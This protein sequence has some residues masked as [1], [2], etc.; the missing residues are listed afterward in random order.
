MFGGENRVLDG[1][2]GSHDFMDNC[3]AYWAGTDAACIQGTDCVT[4]QSVC[5]YTTDDKKG[6][7]SWNRPG[8]CGGYFDME[9]WE[10]SINKGG[11]DTGRKTSCWSQ[12]SEIPE[13]WLDE[14]NHATQANWTAGQEVTLGWVTTANHGGMYEWSL[15]CDGDETY[16]NF[17]NNRLEV[18]PGKGGIYESFTM[19]SSPDLA[20]EEG[21]KFGPKIRDPIVSNGKHEAG[22]VPHW[23]YIPQAIP[24][25][26]LQNV[27]KIPKD[28][29]EGKF[30]TEHFRK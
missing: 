2:K 19:A 10:L 1:G 16:S 13:S 15:I 5:P 17:R 24:N 23:A 28:K 27:Y 12:Q 4:K 8:C 3:P 9:K 14:D 25:A 20:L 26:A 30:H 18:V 7:S 21:G 11:V 6:V 29:V 22:G